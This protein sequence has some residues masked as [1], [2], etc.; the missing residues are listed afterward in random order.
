MKK[1]CIILPNFYKTALCYSTYRRLLNIKAKYFYRTLK[2][3]KGSA[4]K[5]LCINNNYF[6][7][8]KFL[9]GF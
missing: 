5:D 7:N 9:L 1:I 8:L 2:F 4:V 6:L 3:L